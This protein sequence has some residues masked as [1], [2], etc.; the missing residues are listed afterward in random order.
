MEITNTNTVRR[1]YVTAMGLQKS[2]GKT[3]S[4]KIITTDFSAKIRDWKGL[5]MAEEKNNAE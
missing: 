2:G 3:A 4:F 5:I 1:N